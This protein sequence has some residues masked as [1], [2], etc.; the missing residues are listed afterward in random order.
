MTKT[1]QL[2][3]YLATHPNAMVWFHTSNMTLN[4]HLDALY[5]LDFRGER[6]QPSL[7]TFFYGLVR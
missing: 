2:L 4:I 7:Q 1:K 6:P 3:D 5:L